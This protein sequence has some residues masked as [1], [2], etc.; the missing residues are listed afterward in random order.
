MNA[1]SSRSHAIFTITLTQQTKLA[2][3]V[4][5]KVSKCNLV[6]LAGSERSKRT[7]AAGQRLQEAGAINKSLSTLGAVISALAS[8]SKGQ[9]PAPPRTTPP[10]HVSPH[11]HVP[12]PPP[13]RGTG[14]APHVPY[15]D[16]SLTWLLKDCLGGNARAS[17]LANISPA[18]DD[19][20][21]TL[22]T[23]RHPPELPRVTP[24]RPRVTPSNPRVTGTRTP[25]S[26]SSTTRASTS[27]PTPRSSP[28]SNPRLRPSARR[29]R[30]PART[31]ARR[32]PTVTKL[33]STSRRSRRSRS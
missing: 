18:E 11:H 24:S 22:S 9:L 19:E 7:G 26:R 6:D 13:P 23:L 1:E 28:I 5:E 27:I 12:T 14:K 29:S 25:R 32:R 8:R 31:S 3:R 30:A 4:S 10:S 2:N 33:P 20:T 15:R 17:M 21:E 16:S